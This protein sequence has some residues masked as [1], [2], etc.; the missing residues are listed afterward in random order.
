MAT[1]ESA[2]IAAWANATIYAAYNASE[3]S[4]PDGLT[5]AT[6]KQSNGT[7]LPTVMTAVPVGGTLSIGAGTFAIAAYVDASAKMV[8][9]AGKDV[10]VI[11]YSGSMSQG[12]RFASGA[13]LVH[14]LSIEYTGTYPGGASDPI[15][16][17]SACT[18]LRLQNIHA[19]GVIDGV[20]SSSTAPG[21]FEVVGCTI[22]TA[23]DAFEI[24][25][26]PVTGLT[27]VILT[28]TMTSTGNPTVTGANQA[29]AIGIDL[30]GGDFY[31]QD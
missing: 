21:K 11:T 18:D 20:H 22:E 23:W 14:D 15:G 13:A 8:A 4:T 24:H 3:S 30:D 10:T 5:A 31:V 17:V 2:T 28:T 7:S 26:Q 29:R 19:I 9:G 12:L 1:Y 27:V 16:R 6:A 25:N